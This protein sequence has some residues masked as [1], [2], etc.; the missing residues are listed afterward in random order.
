MEPQLPPVIGKQMFR[1][2]SR[3]DYFAAPAAAAIEKNAAR[4]GPGIVPI[5]NVSNPAAVFVAV[6]SARL[7]ML[8]IEFRLCARIQLVADPIRPGTAEQRKGADQDTH[9]NCEQEHGAHHAQCADAGSAQRDD[10]LIP[11]QP[12]ERDYD[13]YVQG[14]RHQHLQRDQRL[15]QHQLDQG[16]R[17]QGLGDRLGQI[18]R[19]AEGS[20]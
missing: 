5:L 16:E 6:E 3:H 17:S 20:E 12:A 1:G 13:G 4:R 10:F 14:Y 18:A 9:R 2:A 7:Q 19:R 15:Q 8:R 11:V